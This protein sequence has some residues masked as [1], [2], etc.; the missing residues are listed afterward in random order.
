MINILS[1][2]EGEVDRLKVIRDRDVPSLNQRIT[3]LQASVD[4]KRQQK[5]DLR[6]RQNLQKS[7]N[8]F[9]NKITVYQLN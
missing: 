1:D 7:M 9:F 5:H 2:I 3:D 8:L 4:R 6:G